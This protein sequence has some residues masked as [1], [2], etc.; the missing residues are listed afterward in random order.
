[1][2]KGILT[3]EA[4]L[5]ARRRT[6][7]TSLG[8]VQIRALSYAEFVELGAMLFDVS[9]LAGDLKKIKS[10]ARSKEDLRK[11]RPMTEML[12]K[13]I[14]GCAVNPKFG[15]DPA[16]GITPGDLPYIDQLALFNAALQLAGYSKKAGKEIRP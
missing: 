4:L 12:E 11:L 13:V 15:T 3:K 2:A 8:E 5:A 1:M 9:A 10:G 14:V 6:V 16:E 7:E